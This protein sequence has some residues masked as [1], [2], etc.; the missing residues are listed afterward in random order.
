M[1]TS[2]CIYIYIYIDTHTDTHTYVHVVHFYLHGTL[3]KAKTYWK[4]IVHYNIIITVLL[5]P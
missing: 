1:K 2:E 3:S 4:N 5:F